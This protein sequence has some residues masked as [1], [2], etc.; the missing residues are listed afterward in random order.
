VDGT[1]WL[2]ID[3]LSPT[4]GNGLHRFCISCCVILGAAETFPK[5][6]EFALIMSL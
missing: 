4:H 3:D 2:I 1:G 6:P 5:D